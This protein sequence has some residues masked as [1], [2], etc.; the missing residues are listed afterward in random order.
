MSLEPFLSRASTD[1]A[2][3]ADDQ[4]MVANTSAAD[5]RPGSGC[6]QGRA[7]GHTKTY[8]DDVEN[9][10]TTSTLQ[11]D[12]KEELNAW[13]DAKDGKNFKLKYCELQAGSSGAK[14]KIQ[15]NIEGSPVK[16]SP[17]TKIVNKQTVYMLLLFLT[18]NVTAALVA[19]ESNSW[20]VDN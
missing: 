11:K 20:N 3:I 12:G 6:N 13:K 9:N 7:G 14:S 17:F 5:L 16:L 1:N 8:A 4:D 19:T 18:A 10:S 2:R 15:K